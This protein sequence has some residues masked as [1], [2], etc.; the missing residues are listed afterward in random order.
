MKRGIKEWYH[1]SISTSYNHN[2]TRQILRL[3]IWQ[4]ESLVS[5]IISVFGPSVFLLYYYYIIVTRRN[6]IMNSSR[7]TL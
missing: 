4:F 2:F 5:Y 1:T 3:N 6:H 7:I